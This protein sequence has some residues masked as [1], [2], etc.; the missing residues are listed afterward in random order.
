MPTETAQK[1][2]LARIRDNQRRSR[3]RRREYL[4]ELEQRLRACELQGVEASAEVQMAA[5]RVAEE[6]RQLRELLHKLG[7][8]DD[9]IAQCLQA[10]AANNAGYSPGEGQSLPAVDAGTTPQSLQQLMLP[11]R[12]AHL[13]PGLHFTLPSHSSR[14]ASIASASTI[15]SSPWECSPSTMTSYSHQP[16]QLGMSPSSTSSSDQ[17]RYSPSVFHANAQS[18]STQAN[19]FQSPRPEHLLATPP[20]LAVDDRT[21]M[22]Y[23]FQMNSFPNGAHRH[24]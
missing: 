13:E 16:Q 18:V 24:D 4:Q 2:N 3:A 23:H 17:P 1:A 12:A 9:Y 5:R 22:N 10:S 11:R 15:N 19:P 14:E 7:A 8:T 6:N 21:M 20:P